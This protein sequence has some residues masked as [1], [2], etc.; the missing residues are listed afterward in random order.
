[1]KDKVPHWQAIEQLLH[2]QQF[3]AGELDYSMLEKEKSL[4]QALAAIGNSAISLFDMFTK[5]HVF[6]SSNF[7]SLFGYNIAQSELDATHFLEDKIHPDDA[8]DL[9]RNGI[10]ILKLFLQMTRE[11]RAKY[12]FI[13]EYRV[14]KADNTYVRVIEQDQIMTFDRRGN[15]WLS[16]GIIDVAPNQQLHEGLKSQVFN[17]VTGEIISFPREAEERKSAVALTPREIEVLRMIKGGLLSKEI[18]DALAISV[19]TVNTHR[20]RILEKLDANNSMEAVTL[21]TNL[22]LL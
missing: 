3:H 8:E 12:K 13:N 6:Y 20:Q 1:M 10:S 16:L 19:H 5:K 17:F 7:G 9:T 21:A 22:G 11:E 14:L 15:M 2:Q 18:S 4:L